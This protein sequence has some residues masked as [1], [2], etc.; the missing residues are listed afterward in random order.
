MEQRCGV[1]LMQNRSNKGS[2]HLDAAVRKLLDRAAPGLQKTLLVLPD[3]SEGPALVLCAGI[4]LVGKQNPRALSN[5]RFHLK[6]P[7][8]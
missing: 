6:L 2:A 5:F 3:E 7:L 4:S 8:V 1:P